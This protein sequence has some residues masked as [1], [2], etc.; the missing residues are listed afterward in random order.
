[1]NKTCIVPGGSKAYVFMVIS[2]NN[3]INVNVFFSDD[4]CFCESRS[5]MHRQDEFGSE[6]GIFGSLGEWDFGDSVWSI[7]RELKHVFA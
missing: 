7:K 2:M 1:M 6:V 4:L 3:H 5:F